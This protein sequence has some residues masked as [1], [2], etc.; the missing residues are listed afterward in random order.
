MA[1]FL[2]FAV[3]TCALA[4]GATVVGLGGCSSGS[5]ATEPPADDSGTDGSLGDVTIDGAGDTARDSAPTDGAP[6]PCASPP[7]SCDPPTPTRCGTTCVDTTTDPE[8]CGSCV[9]SCNKVDHGS[10]SCSSGA[11][12]LKCDTSFHACG[13]FCVKSTSLAN[14]GPSCSPCPAPGKNAN[15]T[16]DGTKC[17]VSCYAGFADCNGGTDGCETDISLNANCGACGT[18]CSGGTP[19]CAPKS[20]GGF[21]CVSGCSGGTTNCSGVCVDTTSSANNCGGC[22]HVC[23]SVAHARTTCSSSICGFL[24]DVG[25]H[26]CSGACVPDDAVSSCGPT[27]CAP[28]PTPAHAAPTCDGVKCGFTCLGGFKDCNGLP[29]DG[30]EVDLSDPKTCGSCTAACPVPPH[31]S[32]TCTSGVCGF[33]CNAPWIPLGDRCA[34]FG[35]AYEIDSSACTGTCMNANPFTKD[36]TCPAGFVTETT[37]ASAECNESSRGTLAVCNAPATGTSLPFGVDWGGAY[38]KRAIACDPATDCFT[39]NPFTGACTCPAGTSPLAFDVED[40]PPDSPCGAT[41]GG[42]PGPPV[43]AGIGGLPTMTQ[44]VFCSPGPSGTGG[45]PITYFGA[46]ETFDD[47]SCR[48]KNPLTTACTCPTGSKPQALRV[49]MPKAGFVSYC[50]P[51]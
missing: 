5:F 30:C 1:R 50:L 39:A 8:H 14:C 45:A 2:S 41:A 27:G 29:G 51:G 18:A 3:A 17:G 7:C 31:G 25:Y 12:A 35:G 4:F 46:F 34:L 33:T 11:C 19:N 22:G 13:K 48:I 37:G 23:D 47:G 49:M 16:C 9:D 20:G 24:C 28:C 43:E 36:C 44:L 15:A 26:G 21:S 40:A 42:G 6:P 32:A 10:T 38:S